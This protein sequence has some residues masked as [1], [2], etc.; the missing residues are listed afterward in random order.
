MFEDEVTQAP[1]DAGTAALRRFHEVM[2]RVHSGADLNSVLE[3]IARSVVEFAGFDQAVVNVVGADGMLEVAIIDGPPAVVEA[4]SGVRFSQE[5]FESDFAEADK[6]GLLL[7]LPAERS[8]DWAEMPVFTNEFHSRED[9][10]DPWH[11][12]DCLVARLEGPTGEL[13]GVLGVD[14]PSDL[15]RPRPEKLQLLEMFA[16]QAGLA[17]HRARTA[18]RL[19]ELAEAKRHLIATV[20]H[21]MRNPLSSLHGHLEILAPEL[22]QTHL[23]PMQR[24]TLRLIGLLDRFLVES[25]NGAGARPVEA[26]RVDLTR[27]VSDEVESASLLASRSKLTLETNLAGRPVMVEGDQFALGRMLANLLSNAVKYSPDGGTIRVSARRVGADAVIRV[28]DPGMGISADDLPHVFTDYYRSANPAS[29]AIDGTGLGLP[30]VKRIVEEHR[31]RISC[32]S[33]LGVGSTFEVRLPVARDASVLKTVSPT[34][35]GGRRAEAAV[36]IPPPAQPTP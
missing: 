32:V 30:I 8:K 12:D 16:E 28:A 21:E 26:A 5:S 34:G 24:S 22:D 4:L 23:A 25:E 2:R 19:S 27:L 18:E 9:V 3:E 13:L 35:D 6:S 36:R 15:R 11:T 1:A 7:F 20:T 14:M 10:P 29:R 31:G 17:I 33:E